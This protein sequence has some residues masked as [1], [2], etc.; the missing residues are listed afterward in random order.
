M[1][2]QIG[3]L[4]LAFIV[5]H[6]GASGFKI[7]T[8]VSNQPGVAPVTDADL[9][10]PWGLAQFSDSAPLWV[11][12]NG[13]DK[14]TLYSRTTGAKQGLV[15][16]IPG[17]A[18]TGQVAVPSGSGFAIGGQNPL[19]LFDSEASIISGWSSGTTAAIAV[20]ETAQGA[21]YKGLAIDPVSKQLYAADFV[22]NHV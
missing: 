2:L 15:V 16:S 22:N 12:D 21:V 4:A 9:V 14:V 19:F 7:V 17:G 5:S 10:N 20:D 13:T 11:S 18:P 8:Q 6:A 1:K 3:A